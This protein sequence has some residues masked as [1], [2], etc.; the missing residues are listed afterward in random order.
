MQLLYLLYFQPFIKRS[1]NINETI[2]EIFILICSYHVTLFTDY[3]S[4][5]YAKNKVGWS[6]IVFCTINIL[7]N[8]YKML[9]QV[10]RKIR[11]FCRARNKK[12]FIRHSLTNRL[13]KYRIQVQSTS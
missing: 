1:I 3:M 4:D 2:N 7:M 13:T 6:L 10:F 12:Q 5:P 8:I 9:R 11:K